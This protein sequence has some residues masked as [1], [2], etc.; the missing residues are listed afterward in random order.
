[1]VYLKLVATM[2]LWG[3]TFVA[4]RIVVQDMGPFSA[5]FCRF[6]VA[7]CCLLLLTFAVEGQLPQP[8]RRLWPAIFL[9]GL[10]GIFAYNTF[11]FA[12]LKTVAAGRAALVIALNP[13][14]IAIGASLVFRE[15]LTRGKILGIGVSLMGA[16]VVISEGNPLLLLQGQMGAGEVF[17]LGCVLSWMGF[18]LMGKTVMTELSPFATTT[19]ACITG[20]GLLLLPAL[21]TGLS[22]AIFRATAQT[23]IGRQLSGCILGSAVGFSWYYDVES[24]TSALQRAS[25]FINLVPMFAIVLAAL[26]LQ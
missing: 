26:L 17:L 20:T 21:N 23:W 2:A 10:T 8:S 13:V 19:Y 6:A 15:P 1:M 18:T 25:V 16:A 4:G 9:L 22:E 12:G 14:A 11:F 3:G 5:A 24:A 7:S